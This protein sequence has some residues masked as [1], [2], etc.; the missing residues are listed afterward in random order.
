MPCNRVCWCSP[1]GTVYGHD[2]ELVA[3]PLLVAAPDL[4]HFGHNAHTLKGSTCGVCAEEALQ[5]GR[6]L[7]PPRQSYTLGS[8]VRRERERKAG[9]TLIGGE[10]QTLRYDFAMA[11][12]GPNIPV[13][14][15]K[16]SSMV[17]DQYNAFVVAGHVPV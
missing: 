11:T 16:S 10:T 4:L 13:H 12:A 6:A 17:Q 2:P 7:S 14:C 3:L 15:N 9:W 8:N 5:G 1:D